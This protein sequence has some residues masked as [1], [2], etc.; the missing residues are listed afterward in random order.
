MGSPSTPQLQAIIDAAQDEARRR[1]Q[2]VE[3]SHLLLAIL[4][5]PE[6]GA[7]R[8]I[9]RR[10]ESTTDLAARVLASVVASPVQRDIVPNRVLLSSRAKAA[11]EKSVEFVMRPPRRWNSCDVLIGIVRDGGSP[12]AD[13]LNAVG[14]TD[15]WIDS[16]IQAEGLSYFFDDSTASL[17]H[18]TAIQRASRGSC[19]PTQH[20]RRGPSGTP[21]P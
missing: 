16:G 21:S 6:C 8:M 17:V 9:E 5:T 11:I 15:E 14:L 20:C 4:H 3:P 18:R 7:Y 10:V 12:A 19:L 2:L 13:I 1:N